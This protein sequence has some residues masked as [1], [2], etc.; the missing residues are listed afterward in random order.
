MCARTRTAFP[1]VV[2]A[3][4]SA[5]RRAPR[6]WAARNYAEAKP[7][8]VKLACELSGRLPRLSLREIS[9][10]LASQGFQTP[11][12]LPYSASAVASMLGH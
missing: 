5:V 10:E 1:A 3:R 6:S 8:M 4:A 12:G 7:D 11:R 9:G 2:L